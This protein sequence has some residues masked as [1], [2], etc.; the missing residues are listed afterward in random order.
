MKNVVCDLDGVVYRGETLI[1]S[2]DEG[3]RRLV[4]AG[5]DVLFATNNSTRTPEEVAAKILRVTGVDVAPDQ[6]VTSSQ[7]ATAVVSPSDGPVFVVGEKGI[8]EAFRSAGMELTKASSSAG[9]V[10]VGLCRDLSYS[11]LSDVANAI[12]NGARFVATNADPTYPTANGLEPGAG[13]IVAAIAAA[14]GVGPEI[15]GKPHS[16]MRSLIRAKLGSD[17]W[18]IGDRI[19]TDMEMA[20]GEPAWKSILVMTGV[21]TVDDKTQRD[22]VAGDLNGAVDLVLGD[23]HRQ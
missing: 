6:I 10:V 14:S 8:V 19:D 4:A 22:Y 12:R 20:V 5:V 11:V 2:A 7:A 21:T 9:V 18:V 1:D 15:V 13:A 23:G 3:L 17:V 16:A